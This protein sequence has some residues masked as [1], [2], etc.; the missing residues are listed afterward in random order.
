M[1]PVHRVFCLSRC[2]TAQGAWV[3]K[4]GRTYII[5]IALSNHSSC[6]LVWCDSFDSDMADMKDNWLKLPSS[7]EVCAGHKKPGLCPRKMPLDGLNY[8]G[9]F[10][11]GDQGLSSE[12]SCSLTPGLTIWEGTAAGNNGDW[13]SRQDH[14]PVRQGRR[15]MSLVLISRE[16]RIGKLGEPFLWPH[17]LWKQTSRETYINQWLEG[18]GHRSRGRLW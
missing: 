10:R 1:S 7:R 9:A 8:N 18:P 11:V 16:S 2:K 15:R 12:L 14:K 5:N 17:D 4:T 13:E 6:W 3:E